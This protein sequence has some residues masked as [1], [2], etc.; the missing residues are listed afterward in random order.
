[1]RK[2]TLRASKK[3]S[4]VVCVFYMTCIPFSWD[5]LNAYDLCIRQMHKSTR[6][7]QQE[8]QDSFHPIDGERGAVCA[9]LKSAIGRCA[10][11]TRKREHMHAANNMLE[12]VWEKIHT[13]SIS[14]PRLIKIPS[15]QRKR[16][17]NWTWRGCYYLDE[18]ADSDRS[19]LENLF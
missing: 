7:L 11:S 13:F 2:M 16:K 17:F 19:L 10:M 12:P 1:M 14:P 4:S 6:F 3:G 8:A 5:A 9:V 18:H 15:L